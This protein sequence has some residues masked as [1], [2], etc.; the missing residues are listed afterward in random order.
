MSYSDG[1]TIPYIYIIILFH[2]C[3]PFTQNVWPTFVQKKK[4]IIKKHN[5]NRSFRRSRKALIIIKKQNNNR[6][7]R[8]SRK[9]L[10]SC[11]HLFDHEGIFF[12]I[13]LIKHTIC[14]KYIISEK[15]CQKLFL[16]L[17]TLRSKIKKNATKNW[18]D[19]YYEIMCN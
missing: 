1:T 4:K 16:E 18:G 9:A 2:C 19:M 3:L 11:F 14:T 6:S 7:F 15:C 17:D 5:N 12:P 8:P 13:K 10:I